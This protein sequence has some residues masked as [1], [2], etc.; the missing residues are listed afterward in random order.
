ML[1]EGVHVPLTTPFYPDGRVYLRK[2]EHNVRRLSLTP[3]SGLIALGPNSESAALSTEEKRSVLTTVADTAAPEKVLVATIAEAGVQPALDLVEHA[4]ANLYDAV[5]LSAPAADGIQFWHTGARAGAPTAE[6]L[7]WFRGIADR[8]LLPILLASHAAG[9]PLPVD[10]IAALAGHPNVLGLLEQSTHVSRV[11]A[12]KAATAHVQRTS[13]T[14]VTFTAA[15]RRMLQP[16][17]P[18]RPAG[19][20]LSAESLAAGGTAVAIAPP[21]PALKTRTKQTGFQLLWAHAADSTQAF[22]AGASA[23]APQVSASIPGAVF[24]IWAA[25]KDGDTAL[26]H[27]KQRRVA[28]SAEPYLLEQGT[29]SIKAAAELSGYFGGRPRLPQFPPTADV[30][31]HIAALLDGMRS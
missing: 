29:A 21:V 24:E 22:H 23:L 1:F 20:L 7:T 14:T 30:Q 10:T 9:Y 2:L 5:L 15:T 26:M 27:E 8:S 3:V 12:V 25:F 6:L 19:N 13:T 16:A 28:S 4:A 11:A 17:P 31:A 18:P